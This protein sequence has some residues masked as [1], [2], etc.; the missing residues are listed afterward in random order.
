M[1]VDRFSARK[2]VNSS[3]KSS[4]EVSF[5]GF[6]ASIPSG[7]SKGKSERSDFTKSIDEC[8][9]AINSS[10]LNLEINSF[11]DLDKLE[12]AFM[13]LGGNPVLASQIAVLKALSKGN[14]F[15]FLNS[16]P[17]LPTPLG[18]CIEG[19]VHSQGSTPDF[20]EFLVIAPKADSFFDAAN[21]NMEVYTTVRDLLGR[22]DPNFK[23]EVT[24]EGAWRTYISNFEALDI[25]KKASRSV[26]HKLDTEIKVGI[27]FASSS[28]FREGFY[29]YKNFSLDK[30]KRKFSRKDQIAFVNGLI[31][32][33]KL[34][35]LEDPFDQD[36]FRAFASL[37]QNK[38][39]ICGDDLTTTNTARIQKAID[40]KSVNCVIIKPNQIGSLTKT[41]YAVKLAKKNNLFTVISHRSEETQD[42]WLSH[43]AVGFD[44]PIVKCGIFGPERTAKLNELIKI[45][46][47]L[48]MA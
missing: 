36:D 18:N 28:F 25:L 6:S 42:T 15:S 8:I 32:E 13:D 38:A 29:Y 5:K 48:I 3:G 40:N 37:N 31:K 30:P 2:V 4:I 10:R 19:G 39:L 27:D 12:V 21:T 33:Y 44:I 17:S 20:Q 43:L 23:N 35:Y 34:Y 9:K 7:T 47:R 11:S 24:A 45:E 14:I 16:S 46:K 22:Y 1:L 26:E 41:F